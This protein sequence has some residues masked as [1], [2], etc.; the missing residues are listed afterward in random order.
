MN[1]DGFEIEHK[2][3][4]AMPDESLLQSASRSHI[5]QT[6]LL[7]EPLTTER[8]RARSYADRD[9]YTHTTK[10]RLS[11]MKRIEQEETVTREMYEALLT[12]ADP[13]RRSI[14]KDRYCLDYAGHT[15]EID[16]FPFWQTYAILEIELEREDEEFRIPP[17]IRVI[18]EVTDDPRYTNSA[19][20]LEI[21]DPSAV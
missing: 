20:S 2:L 18:R 5:V 7:G 17:E 13:A 6:Y 3:L 11:A 12:R 19:L 21:P 10:I 16:V 1:V 15:L 4:I 9:E 14:E 8:V